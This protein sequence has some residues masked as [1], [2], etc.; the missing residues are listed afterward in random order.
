MRT[1]RGGYRNGEASFPTCARIRFRVGPDAPRLCDPSRAARPGEPSVRQRRH[2]PH[3]REQHAFRGRQRADGLRRR[4][5]DL[6]RRRAVRLT[7]RSTSPSRPVPASRA[8]T[9]ASV[10]NVTTS[11]N[12]GGCTNPERAVRC[13]AR[14][15]RA[16]RSAPG[17]TS[18][19]RSAGSRTRRPPAPATASSVLTTADTDVVSSRTYS[20]VAG[21]P[22]HERD[23]GQRLALGRR[24]R[25]H[26]VH[27]R[28][29]A[30]ARRRPRQAA[31]SR[32]SVTFPTG[33]TFAGYSSVD[34]PRPHDVHQRRQL[35][36]RHGADDRV[37]AVHQRRR[38]PPAHAVRVTFGGITNPSTPAPKTISVRPPP[39]CR[40][41]TRRTSTCRRQPAGRGHA[42][43]HPPSAAAGARTQ[44]IADFKAS[45]T[46]GSARPPT[47]A[48]R[49]PSPP[50]PPS[51]ATPARRP[52]LTTA[53]NVGT[54]GGNSG[55]VI[56]CSLFTGTRHRRRDD[57]RVSFG[58]ITNPPPRAPRP[59][60]HHHV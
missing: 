21:G 28:V 35:R 26:A 20:V 47:A 12:V 4:L 29:R 14:C 46:G 2:E 41:S 52:R 57:V 15:S 16:R 45:T 6:G 31:N 49:S 59:S 30:L 39:T 48:S 22:A 50:A 37:H 32:I 8:S 17:T 33:T 58:G 44:Y 34:R 18:A 55:L 10:R 54:C 5:H 51:P 38:S 13:A 1:L 23:A 7:A 43:Q 60:R 42:R 25:P 9:T 36:R 40:P 56:E 53:T 24:R 19:S 11:T 3:R 27:R